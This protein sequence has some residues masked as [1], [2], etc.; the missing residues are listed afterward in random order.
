M[1]IGS[2]TQFLFVYRPLTES[3]VLHITWAQHAV[4]YDDNGSPH[5]TCLRVPCPRTLGGSSRTSALHTDHTLFQQCLLL[6]LHVSHCYAFLYAHRH[7]SFEVYIVLT[8]TLRHKGL[9]S[10]HCQAML[11]TVLQTTKKY[12]NRFYQRARCLVPV[13]PHE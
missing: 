12:C 8:N 1:A 10:S 6:R 3:D 13:S 9:R 2:R 4:V 7:T 11:M 5:A